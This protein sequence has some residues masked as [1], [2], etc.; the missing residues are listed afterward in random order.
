MHPGKVT[1]WMRFAGIG[2]KVPLELEG[3]FHRDIRGA[4]IHLIGCTAE[5]QTATEAERQMKGFARR[6]TGK[7]GDITAGL[8]PRDYVGYP[9]IEWYSDRNGRVVLELEPGQV[10]V[11]GTPIPA[12]QSEPISR[13]QQN[14]NLCEFLCAGATACRPSKGRRKSAVCSEP[15]KTP[16]AA[17]G[18]KDAAC[19]EVGP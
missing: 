15:T 3:D 19:K 11:I 5:T 18:E 16:E 4:R 13:E 2:K 6:Q 7:V 1:G 17:C 12:D 8:L 10:E 14:R 9:Y